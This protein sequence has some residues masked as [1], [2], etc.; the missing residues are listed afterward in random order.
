ME[1]RRGCR[2]SQTAVLRVAAL[3]LL[4]PLA[5]FAPQ[6]SPEDTFASTYNTWIHM[7]DAEAPGTIDARE[8]AQW[9]EVKRAFKTL[10]TYVEVH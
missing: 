10:T 5:L 6:A 7:R 2:G 1:R 9:Q 4:G 8:R 3:L